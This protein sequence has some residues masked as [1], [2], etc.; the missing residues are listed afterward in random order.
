MIALLSWLVRYFYLRLASTGIYSRSL[1]MAIKRRSWSS[2]DD[3]MSTLIEV[4][5]QAKWPIRPELI[6][7]S[8]AWSDW[9]YF[10]S[11]LDGMLVHRRVTPSSKFTG[12]HL[13]TWVERGTMRVKCLDQE[14][15]EVPRP[16]FEPG[17]FDPGFSFLTIRPPRLPSCRR[18]LVRIKLKQ[19]ALRLISHFFYDFSITGASARL[20]RSL[21]RHRSVTSWACLPAHTTR[22]RRLG[23]RHRNY[24]ARLVQRGSERASVQLGI[25]SDPSYLE[26]SQRRY[27]ESSMSRFWST[28]KW[29]STSAYWL[30]SIQIDW[31]GRVYYSRPFRVSDWMDNTVRTIRYAQ[32]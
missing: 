16:G 7:V 25:I 11:T 20:E 22:G 8:I 4:C 18:W 19:A 13:F 31:E 9:E 1:S 14:H 30:T 21:E 5:I 28:S 26:K 15:N 10:H 17:L 29:V 6:P 32:C 12:T 27:S 24:T 23:L 2:W 3:A